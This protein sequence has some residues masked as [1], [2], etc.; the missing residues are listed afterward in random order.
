[1]CHSP[2]SLSP[3]PISSFLRPKRMLLGE[4]KKPGV[5]A[6]TFNLRI[7]KAEAGRSL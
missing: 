5:V 4:K 7:W 1:M 3:L 6:K 2:S